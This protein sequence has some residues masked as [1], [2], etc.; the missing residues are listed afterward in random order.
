VARSTPRLKRLRQ[1]LYYAAVGFFVLDGD[2]DRMSAEAAA[3]KG[4]VSD[5]EAAGAALLPNGSRI[6]AV[7]R[8]MAEEEVGDTR[9]DLH[10]FD[11]A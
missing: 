6:R 10:A 1:D 7:L 11:L 2:S 8:Q 3:E 9:D 4:S 5:I